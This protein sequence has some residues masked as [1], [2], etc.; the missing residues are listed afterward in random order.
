MAA[1]SLG[2]IASGNAIALGETQRLRLLIPDAT[3]APAFA[4]YWSRNRARFAP[5][6][7]SS[8]DVVCRESHWQERL[9]RCPEM[10]EQGS[11]L[12]ALLL[13]EEQLIGDLTFSNV[14]RGPLQACFLGYKIDGAWEGQGYM[15]EALGYAI[16][17]VFATWH[18][19]RIAANHR[20][21]N[22]RSAR[23]LRRLGFVVEGYARDYLLLDGAWRDHVLT[24]LSNANWRAGSK[25]G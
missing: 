1:G 13:R 20:P 17:F 3:F 24:S 2:K 22:T 11:G 16:D 15:S 19:H 23:L 9:A 6:S 5:A 14:T 21:E 4:A 12:T 7:P 25:H 8:G 10:F 18:L